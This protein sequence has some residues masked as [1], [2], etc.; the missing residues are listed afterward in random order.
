MNREL[1]PSLAYSRPYRTT[2]QPS[3]IRTLILQ[4]YL[5]VNFTTIQNTESRDRPRDGRADR[6]LH[7]SPDFNMAALTLY[8]CSSTTLAVLGDMIALVYLQYQTSFKH[9]PTYTRTAVVLRSTLS[10]NLN[11]KTILRSSFQH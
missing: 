1:W 4:I 5:S 6:R 3:E 11:N 9:V 2:S 7:I 10:L 8:A